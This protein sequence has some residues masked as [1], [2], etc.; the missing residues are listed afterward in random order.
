MML[1]AAAAPN[2]ARCCCVKVG[3]NVS[4]FLYKKMNFRI[5]AACFF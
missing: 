1:A 5:L 3:Q 4:S 2:D